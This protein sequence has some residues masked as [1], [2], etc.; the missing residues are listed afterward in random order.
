MRCSLWSTFY[1]L[2]ITLMQALA[3]K[4]KMYALSESKG[5]R[6]MEGLAALIPYA[7]EVK[8]K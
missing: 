1:G 6:M 2:M 3:M 4:G 5:G 8:D 7:P